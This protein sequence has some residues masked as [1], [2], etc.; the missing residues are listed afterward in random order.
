MK[1]KSIVQELEKDYNQLQQQEMKQI[2]KNLLIQ[3]KGSIKAKNEMLFSSKKK[4]EGGGG[5]AELVDAT[6]LIQLS[7]GRKT[8][9]VLAFR[10]RETQVEEKIGDPEPNLVFIT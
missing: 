9:Q 5:M 4:E 2:Q 8:Y 1:S 6:D 3:S 7:L 10:F